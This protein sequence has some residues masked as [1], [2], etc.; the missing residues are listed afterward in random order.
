MNILYIE[1]IC[2]Q[3]GKTPLHQTYSVQPMKVCLVTDILYTEW[4]FEEI[5]KTPKIK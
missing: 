4:T 1:R 2:E 5:G 3:F